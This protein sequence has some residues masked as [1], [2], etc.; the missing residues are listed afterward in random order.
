MEKI[1]II[2]NYN[3]LMTAINNN[4][5]DH[6]I[7]LLKYCAIKIEEYDTNHGPKLFFHALSLCT[8]PITYN[9][10]MKHADQQSIKEINNKLLD[11]KLWTKTTHKLLP[12]E[13]QQEVVNLLLIL[14]RST[15]KI[16]KPIIDIIINT[17]VFNIRLYQVFL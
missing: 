15:Y 16:P 17:T 1:S 8:K 4:N 9:K 6:L 13:K 10:H 14:K 5:F 3:M 11:N 2:A 12:K 7:Q